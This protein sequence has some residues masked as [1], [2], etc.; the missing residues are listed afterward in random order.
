MGSEK[1]SPRRSMAVLKTFQHL[2]QAS[3]LGGPGSSWRIQ[4]PEA[5]LKE[6]ATWLSFR[7]ALLPRGPERA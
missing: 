6:K 1:A 3:M 4:V 7:S 5:M 2:A